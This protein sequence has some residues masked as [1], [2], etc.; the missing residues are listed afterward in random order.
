MEL[1]SYRQ[2]Y[3]RS[4]G[5]TAR[6]KNYIHVLE[7]MPGQPREVYQR[8]KYLRK[9]LLDILGSCLPPSMP[10]PVISTILLHLMATKGLASLGQVTKDDP[11]NKVVELDNMDKLYLAMADVFDHLKIIMFNI[12]PNTLATQPSL[13]KKKESLYERFQLLASIVIAAKLETGLDD[14]EIAAEDEAAS[15]VEKI[16][17]DCKD[18]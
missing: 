15:E 1:D 10:Y 6:D 2:Q 9:V 11:S 7:N 14:L 4:A 5:M 8:I 18:G 12:E 13:N 3:K 17:E 16:R